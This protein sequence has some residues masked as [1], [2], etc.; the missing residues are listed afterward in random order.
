[1]NGTDVEADEAGRAWLEATASCP[2]VDIELPRGLRLADALLDLGV[3]HLDIGPALAACPAPGTGEWELVRRAAASMHQHIGRVTNAP[4]LPGVLRDMADPF[5]RYFLLYVLVALRPNALAFHAERGIDP[6]ITRRTLLDVGRHMA[7]HRRRHGTGGLSVF[8]GW[9]ALHVTGRIHQLG[10]LQFATA[11]LGQRTAAEVRAG[12][13]DAEAGE[14]TLDVHIPDY[15]GPFTPELCDESFAMARS[16]FADHFPEHP[17]LVA[18]CFSWLLDRELPNRL[19]PTSNIVRFQERFTIAHREGPPA[20]ASAFDF[21]FKAP[22][23]A[24]DDVP[25][26]TS[27]QRAVV[28][29]IKDGGHFYGGAGWCLV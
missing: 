2:D 28:E 21:V 24:I 11:K 27:V 16:F 14:P 1:V 10:R 25:Q 8:S 15:L 20:D 17:A 19:A 12:G 3:P 26:E 13:T 22:L 7:H 23:D 5:G 4:E 9:L 18:T 29:H 6:E